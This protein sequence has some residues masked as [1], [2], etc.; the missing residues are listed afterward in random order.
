MNDEKHTQH[1][2]RAWE[3]ASRL[4]PPPAP[5]RL[6]F[7]MPAM[8]PLGLIHTLE[9]RWWRYRRRRLFRR[10]ILPLLAYDDQLLNDM[11]HSRKDILWANQLPYNVDAIHTLE[12]L[13]QQPPHPAPTSGQANQTSR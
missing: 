9:M 5:P 10:H 12:A 3:K 2:R 8:P 6:E 1:V 4:A 13:R 7:Y 11:G